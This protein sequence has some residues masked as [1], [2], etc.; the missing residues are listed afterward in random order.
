VFERDFLPE[1][2]HSEDGLVLTDGSRVGVIGGGPAGSFFTIFLL[3]LARR[4]GLSLE[5]DV[6]EKKD[7]TCEGPRGCNHCGGIVSESLVQLLATEGINLPAE[8]VQ[9]GIESYVLHMDV[10]TVHIETPG[11]EKRIAA[12]ARGA[13]PRGCKANDWV[14]FDSHLLSLAADLG[15]RVRREQ[16]RRVTFV[17]GRPEIAT[18]NGDPEAYDL[19]VGAMGVNTPPSGIFDNAG[20]EY[21]APETTKTFICEYPLG[22]ELV[23]ELFGDSMHVFLLDIPRLK[24]AALVPKGEHVTMCLLGEGIDQELV[25]SF[26]ESEA[27]RSC[28]PAG[29]DVTKGIPCKCFPKIN[30]KSAVQPFADRVLLLGDAAVTRLYKDGIGAAYAT[31]KAAAATAVLHG[32]SEEAFKAHYWPACKSLMT[33]NLL[34]KSIFLFTRLVQKR[35]FAKR[36]ILR[37]VQG[38]QS[39]AK[40]KKAMSGVLWDTFTGSAT[41]RDILLRTVRPGFLVRL[42][43]S[44]T[45][46][47]FGGG[48][49]SKTAGEGHVDIEPGQAV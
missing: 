33:D 26:Q 5:V 48:R 42:L 15:A 29:Y 22:A 34:G 30:V 8:V 44:T 25:R 7:Y 14:S 47:L 46:A 23:Q 36:G 18:K 39:N 37:M 21:R 49:R 19:V 38:E 40:R 28:F 6:F 3:K 27:V 2:N 16:V 10:G 1:K 12:M 24:F 11:Q 31:S 4:I 17:S 41:Y 45:I 32:I 35:G 13:G 43:F 20:I 9:R